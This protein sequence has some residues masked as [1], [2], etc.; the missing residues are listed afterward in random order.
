MLIYPISKFFKESVSLVGY[1]LYYR[2]DYPPIALAY[3]GS[4]LEKANHKVKIV[5]CLIEKYDKDDVKREIKHF[6]PDVVGVTANTQ[7]IYDAMKIAQIAKEHNPNCITVIGGPHVTYMAKETLEEC[8]FIDVVVRGE[9]EI[10]L[11]ELLDKKSSNWNEIKGIT[12]RLNGKIVSNADRG[13]IDDLDSLPFPAYHLL[14]MDKYKAYGH[15]IKEWI[16]GKSFAGVLTSRGCPYN[17]TF[18]A[19]KT[20]GKSW[21]ARSP[22]NIIEE[23][24]ILR[25]KYG[26]KDIEFLDD[27]FT[28]SEKRT[29]RICKL[30]KQEDLDISWFCSTRV[31]CFTKKIAETIHKSGCHSVFFGIESGVQENLDFFNKGF[32][33]EKAEQSIKIAKK[34]GLNVIA[35]FIIGLPQDNKKK[36]WQTIK[37]AKKLNPKIALFSQLTPLPGSKVYDMAEENNLILTKDWS[38]Y[39][40]MY[41]PVIKIPG[42]TNDELI[43]Y[44]KNANLSFYIK[45]SYVLNIFTEIVSTNSLKILRNHLKLLA[46]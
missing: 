14:S 39:I 17:C 36:I 35:Y 22:E 6:D 10:T 12:Y 42:L 5:D 25:D 44:L 21:R 26:K 34:A 29:E 33:L 20:L 27:T 31:D 28:V 1:S 46:K 13:F 32:T 38:K 30:I 19:S 7:I 11:L 4:Y 24:K 8:S 37:F 9:G 40:T 3:I 23:I 43:K 41:D 45:P 16:N 15:L 18:C 2:V